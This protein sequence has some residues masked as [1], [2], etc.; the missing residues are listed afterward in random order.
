MSAG[1]VRYDQYG[2]KRLMAEAEGYVMV[3][4]PHAMPGV[5]SRKEWDALSTEAPDDF[6]YESAKWARVPPA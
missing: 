5:M 1:E 3:R 4:R 6:G 2:A